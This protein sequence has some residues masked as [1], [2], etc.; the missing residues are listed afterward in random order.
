MDVL[1]ITEACGAGVRRH[2]QLIVPALQSNGIKCGVLAYGTRAE[3][4]FENDI[5]AWKRLGSEAFLLR[6]TGSRRENLR[7]FISQIRAAI[8]LFRPKAIHL[9]AFG[10][11]LAGRLAGGAKIIYSP[12]AFNINP[13]MH[14]LGRSTIAFAEMALALRTDAWALVGNAEMADARRLHL[15]QKRLH[16]CQNGLPADFRNSLLPRDKA[17]ALLG[18][19]KTGKIILVPSRLEQQ[20][21]IG[22]LLNAIDKSCNLHFHICGDGSMRDELQALAKERDIADKVTFAGNVPSLHKFL[23]AFDGAVLPSF[24]EGLSYSLLEILAAELP[25]AL[26]DIPANN[27]LPELR[28]H[29]AFFTPGNVQEIKAALERLDSGEIKPV[30]SQE[31]LRHFSLDRQIEALAEIYRHL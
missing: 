19:H 30:A 16:L 25:M 14:F 20:K 4:D 5:L 21:G 11:G 24:Y 10:A 12:H 26:S 13:P 28:Q 17:R 1:H 8:K 7:D 18:L 22:P 23:N 31:I 15:P 9:H 3:A 27:L 6:R 29:A 2:L